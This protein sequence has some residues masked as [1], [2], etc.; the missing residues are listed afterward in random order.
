LP[1]ALTV[2][3][4]SSFVTDT[5]AAALGMLYLGCIFGM[6]IGG[7]GSIISTDAMSSNDSSSMLSL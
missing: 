5:A 1:L 4:C 7:G 6:R 2:L 3:V